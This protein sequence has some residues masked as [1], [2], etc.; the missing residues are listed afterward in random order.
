MPRFSVRGYLAALPSMIRQAEDEHVFRAYV[1]ES[2]RLLSE[3]KRFVKSYEEIISRKP[4]DTRSGDEIA[5]EVI[6]RAG[7]L[8]TGGE[9][10]A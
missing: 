4:V 1:T 6:L 10:E 5:A 7:L 8:P 3:G 9:T 2:I